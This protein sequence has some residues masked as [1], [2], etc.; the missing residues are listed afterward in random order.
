MQ[1]EIKRRKFAVDLSKIGIS[2]D[3]KT[4]QVIS[5]KVFE[6]DALMQKQ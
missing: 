5:G 6:D 2:P 3:Q 4:G 1:A